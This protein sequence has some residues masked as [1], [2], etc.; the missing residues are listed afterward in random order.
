M[1][2]LVTKLSYGKYQN[3][4]ELKGKGKKSGN[5]YALE[6]NPL[7]GDK[8]SYMRRQATV[9]P[10]SEL[11]VHEGDFR[12]FVELVNECDAAHNDFVLNVRD[13]AV[14]LAFRT[15]CR[16][17]CRKQLNTKHCPHGYIRYILIR[18]L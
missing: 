11:T 18:L 16:V 7:G 9:A 4:G 3:E 8:Q 5:N 6:C 15:P 1:T 17:N 14:P 2:M 10:K 13:L 12:P